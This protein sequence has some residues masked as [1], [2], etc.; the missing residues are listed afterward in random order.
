MTKS[1]DAEMKERKRSSA[2]QPPKHSSP[3]QRPTSASNRKGDMPPPRRLPSR[4][5]SPQCNIR[6]SQK[7]LLGIPTSCPLRAR[8][9]IASKTT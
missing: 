5:R 1:S 7:I 3:A 4:A 9:A 8:W 6:G 2:R